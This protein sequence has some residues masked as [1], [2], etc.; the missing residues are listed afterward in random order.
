MSTVLSVQITLETTIQKNLS[1]PLKFANKTFVAEFR[2]S[3]TTFFVIHGDFTYRGKFTGKHLC[4]SLFFNKVA[5]VRHL[6]KKRLWHW[7]FP[8][9]FVK[10]LIT[11]FFIEHLRWLLLYFWSWNLWS[12]EI[13]L[14]NFIW[15]SGLFS[16]WIAHHVF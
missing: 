2:K 16:I 4:Q 7:C 11:P 3:Q 9:N 1:N 12:Y 5:G 10:F 15:D 6:L 14:W 13:L 8:V